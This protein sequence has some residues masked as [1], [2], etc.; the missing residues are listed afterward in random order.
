MST[1]GKAIPQSGDGIAFEGG[2]DPTADATAT[3]E[4]DNSASGGSP[5]TTYGPLR[6]VTSALNGVIGPAGGQPT[7]TTGGSDTSWSFSKQVR[8][9]MI[10][11]NTSAN[12]QFNFEAAATAGS[13]ILAPGSTLFFDLRVTAVHLL[14]A[15][16]QNINGTSAGNI[17]VWGWM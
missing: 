12:V 5:A 4:I 1:L 16:N 2:Y 14:T 9:V 6:V 13:P 11:N 17:V 8:H 7:A 10:Q 15:A 3:R